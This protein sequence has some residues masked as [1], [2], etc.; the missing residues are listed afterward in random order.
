MGPCFKTWTQRWDGQK[1]E[2]D[3]GDRRGEGTE[4]MRVYRNP[5]RFK[6]YWLHHILI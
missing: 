1:E 3:G 4:K 5:K 6:K 2:K